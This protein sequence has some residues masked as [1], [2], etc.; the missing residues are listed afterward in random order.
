MKRGLRDF[1]HVFPVDADRTVAD[2]IKARDELAERRLAAAGGP[3]DGDDLARRDVHAHI[4][5]HAARFLFRVVG[6]A[7]MVNIDL[8][9]AGFQFLG[10]RR[11]LERGLHAHQR[12][13]TLHARK[14][15]RENL[16]E[17]R[18]LAHGADEGRDV[19]REGDEV[20]VVHLA[21]HD[22]I[23][24]HRDNGGGEERH[25]EF[26]RRVENAHLVVEG[27]LGDLELLVRGVEFSDLRRFV[28]KGACRADARE[29]GLDAD[30]DGGGLLLFVARGSAHLAAA[31]HDGREEH[32]QD[33]RDHERQ[34]PFDRRHDTERAEDR[35]RG[36][37]Q[38]LRPVV[39]K[40]RDLEEVARQPAHELA[41]AVVVKKAH[42]Q[43]LHMNEEV[44]ADV[45]LHADAEGVAPVGDDIVQKRAHKEGRHHHGHHGEKRAVLLIGQKIV[46]RLARH[47]REGKVDKG[48]DRCAHKV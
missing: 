14:T 10:V 21:A 31:G 23:A 28:G 3:H 30:V 16:R 4:V 24:A 33:A 42:V 27:A 39:G 36:D 45:R 5:Q 6:K 22:E 20:D 9:A 43:L 11:I 41:R 18:E 1:P 25:K 38:I 48:N 37:E 12:D 34:A 46:H 19:E 15:A 13:E 44:A 29:R 26:H 8:A 40:L 17:V 7:H 35:E 2:L 32:R 47:E